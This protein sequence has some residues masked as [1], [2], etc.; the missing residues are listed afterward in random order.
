VTARFVPWQAAWH[1]AL[2]GPDGFYRRDDGPAAHF[3]TGVHASQLMAQALSRLAADLGLR[4]VVD[5]GSGR[6]ELL[7][8]L[9][10]ADPGLELVGVDVVHRPPSLPEPARW[11]VSPGGGALPDDLSFARDALVVAHE[12][13]DD[14]PCPVVESGPAGWRQV[15]VNPV[16]GEE[17][18]GDDVPGEQRAWLDR[19]W[20]TGGRAEVGLARDQAWATL[21]AAAEGSVLLAV[22]YAH[23]TGA[24]PADGTLIGYRHGRAV[25]PVPD[26]TC[27][28][29]AHVAIDAVARAGEDAGA[30][31]TVLT[32]QRVALRSVG[33]SA[34]AP[35]TSS[36]RVDP[37]RYLAA[38]QRASETSEL[39]DPGG[40]GAFAWLLQTRGPSLPTGVASWTD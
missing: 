9:A 29:T 24:R 28:V 2:Y 7:D 37:A 11:F 5:V 12:W 25:P 4:R 31:G 18:L 39:L 30:T 23:T 1:H 10:D 32:T 26:G 16:T 20:P 35:S 36:A 8:A 22:D 14:V 21:V 34:E 15:D 38:L 13:L 27:D 3:R 40:L 6:G 17:R 19:W 33:V